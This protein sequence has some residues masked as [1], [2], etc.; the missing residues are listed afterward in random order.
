MDAVVELVTLLNKDVD[1]SLDIGTCAEV[2]YDMQE[3]P[4]TAKRFMRVAYTA[5]C[6]A[7]RVH[8]PAGAVSVVKRYLQKANA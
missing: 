6:S 5:L 1:A 4:A 2:L 8:N 3:D 7:V